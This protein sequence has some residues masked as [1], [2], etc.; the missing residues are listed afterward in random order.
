VVV[1]L[2]WDAVQVEQVRALGLAWE[3][4]VLGLVVVGLVVVELVWEP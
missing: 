4:G 3:Q 1:L 2:G